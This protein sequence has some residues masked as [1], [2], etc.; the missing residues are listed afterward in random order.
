M[1]ISGFDVDALNKPI[2]FD[3]AFSQ[4]FRAC[5]IKMGGNNLSGNAPYLM[6]SNGG[7]QGQVNQAF[8]AGFGIVG[9]YW[10]VGGHSPAAS[11]DFYAAHRD[12]RT[13]F[14]VIDN[15]SIDAGNVWS[16]AECAA[17]IDRLASKDLPNFNPWNYAN[18]SD[19]NAHSWPE[20]QRRGVKGLVA[21]Y[22]NSPLQNIGV[23]Y[24]SSLIFGHQYTSSATIGGINSVDA[25][26]FTDNAFASSTP[27]PIGYRDWGKY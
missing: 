4:G 24:P 27:A 3:R 1:T 22:N 8:S 16:D 13:V 25:D 10:M 21:Y 18:K 5:Y 15:E 17:F 19:W 12:P 9:S 6:T 20:L 23:N 2:S 14:D 26:I 11:A 7:Y